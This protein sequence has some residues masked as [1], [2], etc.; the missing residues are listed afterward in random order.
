MSN[1]GD[2]QGA[3]H[4]AVLVRDVVTKLLLLL[5]L[6]LLR[7]QLLEEMMREPLGP[8]LLVLLLGEDRLRQFLEIR[9]GPLMEEG[10]HQLLDRRPLSPL[11]LLLLGIDR[12][13]QLLEI[14]HGPLLEE[15][16]HQLRLLLDLL[17]QLLDHRPLPPLLGLLLR[18]DQLRHCEV[19]R[20]DLLVL[21]G[22]LLLLHL[23]TLGVGGAG[24]EQ[25]IK[26][27]G[28][29]RHTWEYSVLHCC[30]CSVSHFWL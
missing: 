28:G 11:L 17:V 24:L 19:C 8:G 4:D 23:P 3:Y 2:D 13:R 12:L 21:D 20:A 16:V 6:R 22:A 1:M 15:F 18:V 27:D 29:P 30:E 14:R 9:H 10:V 7:D 26:S 5:V 25:Q